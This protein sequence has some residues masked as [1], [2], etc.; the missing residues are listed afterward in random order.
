MA[1]IRVGLVGLSASATGTGWAASA[2]LPYLLNSPYYEI[3]ALCNSNVDAAKKAIEA[4]KLP[5][6]TKAYGSPEDLAND[7]DI[8]L[9]VANV[10]VDKHAEVLLPSLKKGKDVF[11][12]WPLD[13]NAKVAAEMLEAARVGG[14]KAFLGLQA[15][16]SPI[17]KKVKELIDSGR[18]GNVLSSTFFGAATNGGGEEG[19]TVSYFT[20][21]HVGGNMFS[22]T[23]GHGKD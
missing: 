21:R 9:V 23:F 13:K 3:K 2:H 18:I 19:K 7:P 20:D 16:Q 11:C 1:P 15:R 14:G 8:D 4:Y 10:R 6:E 5:A 22:I 17:V 12:E